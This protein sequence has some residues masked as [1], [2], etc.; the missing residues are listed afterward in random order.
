MPPALAATQ[1]GQRASAVIARIRGFLQKAPAERAPVNVNDLL[2]EKPELVNSD[3]LGEGWMIKVRVAD[4]G[5]VE[6]L[7]DANAYD[8][9]TAAS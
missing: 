4:R 1:D 8:Q 7:L 5:Q 6:N 2:R 3:P 9:L